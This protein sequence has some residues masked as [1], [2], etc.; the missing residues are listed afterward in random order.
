MKTTMTS[1]ER[2]LTSIENLKADYIPCSFMLFSAL[3]DQYMNEL[4][5]IDKQID[6]GIDPKVELHKLPLRFHK[7]VTIKEYMETGPDDTKLIVKEYHTPKGLLTQKVEYTFDWS[8]GKHIPLLNDHII[9]RSKKFIMT[10]ENDLD[11]LEYL[12]LPPSDVDIAM[13]RAG[14]NELKK[15]A[16]Q[17][18]LLVSGG[19]RYDRAPDSNEGEHANYGNMGFD[20]LSWLCGMET[21]LMLTYDNQALVE[22]LVDIVASW[23]RKRLEIELDVEPDL[24]LRRGW[25]ESADIISPD[26]YRK[27]VVPQLKKDIKMVHQAGAKFGYIMTSGINPLINDLLDLDID[28]IVGIDP[29]TAGCDLKK[30]KETLGSKMC[31]WGGVSGS[32]TVERG[33]KEDIQKAVEDCMSMLGKNGGFILSPVDNITENTAESWGNVRT[34]LETW[35]T[36]R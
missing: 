8:Y 35:K 25:Y 11:A 1:K 33:S 16:N 18:G 15:F 31:L 29:L 26:I 32:L 19:W 13:F 27:Y 21:L 24:I 5:Y 30:I 9:T 22:R 10:S 3:C 14:A 12:F 23:N 17:R 34:F 28:V 7:D 6:M 4:D 36:L 20:A 2:M